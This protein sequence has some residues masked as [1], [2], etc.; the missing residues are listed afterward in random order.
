MLAAHQDAG[1]GRAKKTALF[2]VPTSPFEQSMTRR[3]QAHLVRHLRPG[4]K[5]ETRRSRQAE[6][7]FQPLAGHLFDDRFGWAA[8]VNCRILVPC[9]CQPVGR[10]A[11]GS[12]PPMTQPKKREA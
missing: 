4:D 2:D 11:A 8:G 5:R 7:I 1:R 10:I 12:A 6:N 9:G 3:C